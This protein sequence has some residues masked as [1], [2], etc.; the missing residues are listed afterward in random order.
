[1]VGDE[2][3]IGLGVLFGEDL[4][5]REML[6]EAGAVEFVLLLV[7]VALGDEDDAMAG[8]E[9]GEG[10]GYAREEFD[11][12]IGDGLSEAYDAITLLGGERAVG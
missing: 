12:L 5:G 3:V 9:V 6:G 10:V 1:V 8:G 11:F 7:G 2:G 4:N